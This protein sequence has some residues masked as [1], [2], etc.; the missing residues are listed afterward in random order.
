VCWHIPGLRPFTDRLRAVIWPRNFKLHDLDTYD[1]KANPEQWITLYKIVVRAAHGD[2][3]VMANYLP[4]VINQST[5][6]WLLSLR[7]GFINTWVQLR[8]AFID[9]Y[10]ATC[11]QPGNKYDLEKVRDYPNEPLHDYIRRFSQ[12]QISIPNINSDGLSP[13]SSEAY[14]TMMP[15]GP[16]FSAKGLNLF[17]TFS[18]WRRSGQMRMRP[19]SRSRRT[20]VRLTS[21]S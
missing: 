6:Q 12:T 7:E 21:T 19:T 10:M 9:N 13:R 2:E 5:N 1:G 20:L 16:I 4:M 18:W 11:L 3:D 17:R 15:L 14:A 8:R